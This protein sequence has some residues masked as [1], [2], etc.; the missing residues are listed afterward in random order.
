MEQPTSNPSPRGARSLLIYAAML[1]G[2]GVGF[3]LIRHFGEQMTASMTSPQATA[4]AAAPVATNYLLYHVLLALVA[5]TAIG[6]IL[7]KLLALFGQP[8]VIG[9][10]LAGI[11][12]GPSLLGAIWPEASSYLLPT[13]VAPALG[14]VA[15]LG[16]ILYM[17]CV[18]LELDI[19]QLRERGRA[20]I[21]ISHASIVVPFLLGSLLALWLFPRYSDANVP[22]TP[23]ALFLGAA[24][25]VTAFPVLARILTDRGIANTPLGAVALT[26]AAA[27][28][29]TAWCLLAFVVSVAQATL[30]AG[31]VVIA[32][33]FIY[34]AAMWWIV[35]PLVHRW[36]RS[37]DQHARASTRGA[38]AIL[39][40]GVFVSALL[41]E[42]I[43]IHAIFGAFLWGAIAP[44][45][46]RIGR[47]LSAKLGDTVVVLLLP[48]FFAF[49]GM[50]TQIGLLHD[51]Y[52]WLWCG[53]IILMATVG[54]FGGSTIA[55]RMTG[56]SWRDAMSLGIL[57]NT[58]G[59]MELVVL[60][61]GLDLQIIS[62]TIFTMMVVMAIV[63]TIATT[64]ILQAIQRNR[65]HV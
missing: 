49:T 23:F 3:L 45:H 14:V 65:W 26:C 50:R 59:L 30:G 44:R 32:G 37:F 7:G 5:V 33:T 41:T 12:V 21:A 39:C 51:W 53:V 54:K 61:I 9:E 4:S 55:A 25:S 47:E 57:M 18:G 52:D 40:L 64:P 13:N 34:L 6:W 22:F 35:R 46:S 10:V 24:M 20:T 16:V 29:V 8:P 1:L 17:F 43:G 36:L 63:T 62:P 48:A 2:A 19:G 15:Q 27:D 11:L 60:N 38:V 58:R 28:D 31:M 56:S 42:W